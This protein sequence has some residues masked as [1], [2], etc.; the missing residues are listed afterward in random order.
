VPPTRP[1]LIRESPHSPA[2][3]PGS[4]PDSDA[5]PGRS[6]RLIDGS[7]L[8]VDPAASVNERIAAIGEAQR[9]R[10][11]R[12]QLRDAG[13]SYSAIDRRARAGHLIC[14]HPGVYAIGSL[15]AIAWADETAALLRCGAH[16]ALTD[17][18]SMTLWEI[19][20]GRARPIHVTYLGRRHGAEPDGVQIHRSASLTPHQITVH[21]GL[22]V[23]TPAR[24]LLDAAATHTDA[25]VA[26]WATTALHKRLTTV[27]AIRRTRDRSGGHPG[28]AT[29]TRAMQ[30]L[31]GSGP[32]EPGGE[33]ELAALLAQTS[34]PQP[35]A[36]THMHGYQCDFYWPQARLNVEADSKRFHGTPAQRERDRKR[37]AKLAKAGIR[38]IR[39]WY[40][41]ISQQ[42]YEVIARITIA[43]GEHAAAASARQRAAR[44]PAR[45]SARNR[46][47]PTRRSSAAARGR[48]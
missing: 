32:L 45:R 36:N 1:T 16:A 25:D 13:L 8:S 4:A 12:S 18:S 24:A 48:G 40:S 17:H 20:D 3:R 29:L 14:V 6:V 38:V 37:D 10:V 47:R 23:T 46:P 2:G 21:K 34:L 15:A 30:G 28:A 22:P 35:I 19:R 11:S 7:R 31:N 39:F 44:S 9:A 42:P 27:D 5:E 33:T 41:E 43:L 26:R